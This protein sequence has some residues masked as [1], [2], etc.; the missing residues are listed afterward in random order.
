MQMLKLNLE[1][2]IFAPRIEAM[3]Q[4][5]SSI[6]KDCEVFIE[7]ERGL[8]TCSIDFLEENKFEFTGIGNSPNSFDY[9]HYSSES[10][11]KERI[12][13]KTFRIYTIPG[14]KQF[15]VIFDVLS[16]RGY[17]IAVQLL[18]KPTKCPFYQEEVFP[19]GYGLEFELKSSQ[20]VVEEEQEELPDDSEGDNSKFLKS[21]N[22]PINSFNNIKAVPNYQARALKSLK[23]ASS[24]EDILDI[25]TNLLLISDKLKNVKPKKSELSGANQIESTFRI[26][27]LELKSSGIDSFK[28]MDFM[29]LFFEMTVEGD[30]LKIPYGSIRKLL[31]SRLTGSNQ[32]STNNQC[33]NL[34]S[35]AITFLNNLEKDIR[36]SKWEKSLG[37]KIEN[38]QFY[39][40]NILTVVFPLNFSDENSASLLENLIQIISHGYPLRLAIVPIVSN[41]HD[42]FVKSFFAV[43]QKYGLRA[44]VKYL[45]AFIQVSHQQGDGELNDES[46]MEI[47][48]IVTNE[49]NIKIDIND[50]NLL[51]EEAYDISRRFNLKDFNGVFANGR[52]FDLV[53]NLLQ[54]LLMFYSE[55]LSFIFEHGL[56]KKSIDLYEAILDA[57]EAKQERFVID[58][59]FSDDQLL[60]IE[61]IVSLMSIKHYIEP[62]VRIDG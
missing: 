15:N 45:N 41:D 2:E 37:R 33:F 6:D 26:N 30:S 39:G 42:L 55:E 43:R 35:D 34:Q 13:T 38:G 53:P 52:V 11:E 46:Q 1:M 36:Y 16:E 54:D 17:N 61:S 12:S 48:E 14:T 9:I 24:F 49:L 29:N 58:S 5:Q 21:M 47:I 60:P 8:Y 50:G 28:I 23:D 62:I 7:Y 27:D 44:T 59:R 18:V 3:S 31:H 51:A 25:S 40:K 57:K 32:Q 19:T 4:I 56:E 10:E 22:V 20:Y